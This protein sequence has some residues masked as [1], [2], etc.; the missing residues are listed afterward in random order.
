MRLV[1]FVMIAALLSVQDTRAQSARELS[2]PDVLSVALER[3]PG[4]EDF[5]RTPQYQASGWLAAL[6]SVS[7]TYLDSDKP[8]GVD[9]T[10][11][12]LR[13]PIKGGR[14]RRADSAL[15]ELSGELRSA[16]SQQRALYFSGLIR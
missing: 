11:A 1:T 12:S 9:E 2:L 3:A 5:G 6:P 8:N 13:L 15:Q 4:S 10:E 16:A 7:L 14:R